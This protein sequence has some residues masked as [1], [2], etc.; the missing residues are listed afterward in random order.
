MPITPGSCTTA[1][2]ASGG[3]AC[4]RKER[5]KTANSRCMRPPINSTWATLTGSVRAPGHA[6]RGARRWMDRP[7]TGNCADRGGRRMR[8]GTARRCL[9]TGAA[10][11]RST[12]AEKSCSTATPK[13][14][15]FICTR[16]RPIRTPC[17]ILTEAL[18]ELPGGE[19][20]RVEGEARACEKNRNLS[21]AQRP[22]ERPAAETD[23]SDSR[24]PLDG[25]LANA[26]VGRTAPRERRPRSR[27]RFLLKHAPL[28]AAAFRHRAPPVRAQ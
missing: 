11:F 4:A 8:H 6:F 27:A 21:F 5:S 26:D 13:T 3:D 20:V 12:M 19:Q 25:S 16:R 22:V 7:M 10:I 24:R 9:R 18:L 15:A 1:G 14:I 23:A 2:F 28:L 17:F